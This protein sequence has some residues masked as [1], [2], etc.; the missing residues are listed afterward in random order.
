MEKSI[1]EILNKLDS[2]ER[3][4]LESELMK[5]GKSKIVLEESEK[6]YREFFEKS[7]DASL[8]INNGKFVDCNFAAVKMLRYNNKHELFNTHPSE[9]SPEK[10]PDGQSSYEKANEMMKIALEK[11][12]H[13][14]EWN[15][16]RADGEVFPVEV[17]LVSISVNEDNVVLHTVWRDISEQKKSELIQKALYQISEATHTASDMYELYKKIHEV[18][19]TLMPVKNIYIALYDEKTELV[20]FPYMVDEYDPPY[21]PKKL[22]RG[23]TEYVFNNGKACLINAEQ[24]MQLRDKGDVD[25]IGTPAAIW[26]G[27]PLKVSGKTIGV[28]TVQDYENEWAY[29][30]DEMQLLA[31]VSEQIG[32]VIERKRNADAIK[33]YTEELKQLNQT[34]DKLFSIIAHDLRSPFNATIGLAEILTEDMKTLTRDEIKSCVMDI[35]NSLRAQYRMLENLLN[36]SRLQ[37]GR[38]DFK[39]EVINLWEISDEVINILS[40]NAVLKQIELTNEIDKDI[41]VFADENML[42][43][44]IHNLISNAIKFTRTDGKVWIST[45]GL[46]GFQEVM[47]TD[48]GVGMNPEETDKIFRIDSKHTTLGTKGE[49]GTGLGLALIKEMVEKHNCKIWVDSELGKGSIFHFTLPPKQ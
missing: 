14:F 44:I 13:R 22:G 23:L 33:L 47:V 21:E 26:L 30:E 49:K 12:S 10:Q 1:L 20:S 8:I 39:Q 18:V 7:E 41:F 16:K 31:F 32:Q 36:W 4:I 29:G 48:N 38:M 25:L 15:H 11:G 34:K 6:K 45:R 24:D 27:V 3:A 28:I 46:D 17:L 19:A 37:T 40:R 42:R 35:S 5:Y 9:L 43:S 2:K